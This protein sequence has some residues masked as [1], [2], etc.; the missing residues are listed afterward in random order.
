MGKSSGNVRYATRGDKL[1]WGYNAE[2]LQ[3]LRKKV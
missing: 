3:A 2:R 1:E